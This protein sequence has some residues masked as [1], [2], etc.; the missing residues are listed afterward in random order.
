MINTFFNTF[1]T[2]KK[3]GGTSKITLP[4]DPIFIFCGQSNS[5]GTTNNAQSRP[6]LSDPIA[7]TK[8]WKDSTN[9]F[10]TTEYQQYGMGQTHGAELNF[11]HTYLKYFTN[12]LYIIKYAV[13]GTDLAVDW[14]YN[15]GPLYTE[16]ISRCNTAIQQ[17]IDA[18]KNVKVWGFDWNQGENDSVL[19]SLGDQYYNNLVDFSTGVRSDIL[20][21][22]EAAFVNCRLSLEYMTNRPLS[23]GKTQVRQAH[24]DHGNLTDNSWYSQDGYDFN[25]IDDVHFSSEYQHITGGKVLG[26]MAG[27]Y[28]K[29]I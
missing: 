8:I 17:L 24:E 4:F 12:P 16:L 20:L 21:A 7:G 22:S 28:D 11:A 27:F 9:Q 18:G 3:A 26:L 23:T 5:L 14:K 15:T 2:I 1:P 29:G 6:A 10:I 25:G 19:A 13:G